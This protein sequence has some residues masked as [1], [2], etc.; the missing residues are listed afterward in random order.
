MIGNP[1]ARAVPQQNQP[2]RIRFCRREC[3]R[4]CRPTDG[5][6]HDLLV[7]ID[8]QT[9]AKSE[10]INR[11]AK[12]TARNAY[13]FRNPANQRLRVRCATT[14]RGRGHLGTRR[15]NRTH[16]RRQGTSPSTTTI[17]NSN[18]STANVKPSAPV[19]EQLEPG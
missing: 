19:P 16:Q 4:S 12:L 6:R 18:A 11:V 8:P 5:N 13:G 17:I 15:T 10:G 2:I 1:A 7:G 14:R 9:N 3:A